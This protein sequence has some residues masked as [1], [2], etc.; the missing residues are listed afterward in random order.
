MSE[1]SEEDLKVLEELREAKRRR[2]AIPQSGRFPISHPD[3]YSY[4]PG[5]NDEG[6]PFPVPQEED[7]R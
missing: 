4:P 3:K 2:D 6:K 1:L 5:L 7:R